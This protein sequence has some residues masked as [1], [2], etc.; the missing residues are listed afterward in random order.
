[1]KVVRSNVV[2]KDNVLEL[3]HSEGFR[4]DGIATAFLEVRNVFG[5]EISCHSNDKDIGTKVSNLFGG[6]RTNH[7]GHFVI[8][9][10][11]VVVLSFLL[12]GLDHVDCNLSVFGFGGLVSLELQQ[13]SEQF[14]VGH[15]VV[16]N[17]N[18]ELVVL[19]GVI[20]IF[21]IAISKCLGVGGWNVKDGHGHGKGCSLSKTLRIAN[22]RTL[23]LFDNTH[24]NVETKSRTVSVLEFVDIE[25]DA[26]SKEFLELILG[27]TGSRILDGDNEVS[28]RFVVGSVLVLQVVLAWFLFDL[29]LFPFGSHVNVST[30]GCEFDGIR[31]EISQDLG[32]TNGISN[33]LLVLD[34]ALGNQ[35]LWVSLHL[36]EIKVK[37]NILGGHGKLEFSDGTV[38]Q[39]P[40]GDFFQLESKL[41]VLDLVVV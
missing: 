19:E 14:S 17:Q 30:F 41:S 21:V 32:N 22:E 29:G 15:G 16:H 7:D 10:N 12:G 39:V 40:D 33:H 23:V 34:F 2:L 28:S 9:Q 31:N 20:T 38:D 8:H 11:Q 26:L 36:W 35:T 5:H 37:R 25:L 6:N 13:T 18:I 3:S 24:G 27:H 1:M 4:Q